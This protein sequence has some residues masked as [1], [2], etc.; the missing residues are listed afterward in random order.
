MRMWWADLKC[1]PGDE[2]VGW[3]CDELTWSVCL[4][5]R[6]LDEDVMSWPEVC[7]WWWGGWMRMW[8]ADLKCVPGDEEVGWGCD[9]L[10]WSVCLVMRR[11]DEDVMSWPSLR[12]VMAGRSLS[13][14]RHSRR[15]ARPMSTTC[16][17][18]TTS[19]HK[20]EA[21]HK[22]FC[23]QK[24]VGQGRGKFLD[25]IQCYRFWIWIRI[26]IRILVNPDPDPRFLLP[27]MEKF[28]VEQSN[29]SL[30]KF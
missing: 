27:K 13:S 3:G 18:G 20:R 25:M 29:S 6:R 8:W 7:A 5:M 28:T 2:E 12:Q 22:T 19:A 21:F 1:V 23:H 11:L 9:E 10:T 16:S 17:A 4:V 24:E 14:V 15:A 30:N 26:W